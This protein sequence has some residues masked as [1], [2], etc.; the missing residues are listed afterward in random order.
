[1]EISGPM[2]LGKDLSVTIQLCH[3]VSYVVVA[4]N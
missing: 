4:G 1:M 2:W 3:K